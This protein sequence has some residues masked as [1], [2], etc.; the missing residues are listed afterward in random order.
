MAEQRIRG[1]FVDIPGRRI[2]PAEITIDKGVIAAIT[3]CAVVDEGYILPGFID[4]HVHV[5]SSMLP[6]SSFARL[7]VV[8]GTVATVSDP[9]E[10][11]NVLGVP[12]VE[13][14]IDNGAEVPFKFFF[15]AP[16]CVPAT[17]FETAGARIDSAA[18]AALLERPE[19][20]YLSE[21]MDFPGVLNGEEEVHRKLAHARRLGKPVDG[22]APGLRGEAA[23][24][25]IQA[26]LGPGQVAIST[27]HEC[28][29]LDEALDKLSYGMKISIREGSAAKNLEAL[30]PLLASHPDRVMLCTDDMHPDRLVQ[31]HINEICARC[32]AQGVDVFNVLQAACIN[33]V[34]HYGLPV[35]QLRVGDTADLIVVEDLLHFRVKR[36]YIAGELVAEEGVSHIPHVQ[37]ATPNNFH[38]SRKEI[39]HFLVPAQA[40]PVLVMEAL[41]GQLITHK[42]YMPGKLE[43]DAMVPDTDRDLLKIAVVNRY[44]DA[45][46]ALGWIRNIGLQRGA[47]ASSVA[48]DSHNIV[49][50]GANDTDLCAAVNAV[51]EQGG[52]ISL[53]EGERRM[54]LALPIAGIMSD[55]DPYSVASEYAAMDRAAKGLGSTLSAPYMT[56][57]FMALLVIPHLKMSDKG[58]F[59]G[60][61]HRL[62]AD[63]V[64]PTSEGS[65]S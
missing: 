8:H 22:H 11:A 13:Y 20:T 19:I 5:E 17:V 46:V 18:V 63:P 6:P 29:T 47:I 15:G 50:V 2:F 51:I 62:L 38:C 57:S 27:D 33:P 36:T 25:Y 32:V 37:V 60:D 34:L 43:G 56:L 65:G 49:A 31:G 41:D 55:A 26:G 54:V 10:I 64:R 42:R 12:G 53:V 9:H 30:M 61:E 52:G 7:A 21:V 23:E 35:G 59:D 45:P 40:D 16:S 3:P 44:H 58:L 24:R 48:H 1:K 28:F 39:A 14:M 4:A